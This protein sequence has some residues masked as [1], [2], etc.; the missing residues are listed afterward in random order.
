MVTAG[1]PVHLNTICLVGSMGIVAMD[2]ISFCFAVFIAYDL[3]Q[4][5]AMGRRNKC[6]YF[7][8]SHSVGPLRFTI[9]LYVMPCINM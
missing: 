7:E 8:R 3:V 5:F 9:S 1:R 4:V 6:Y 2:S